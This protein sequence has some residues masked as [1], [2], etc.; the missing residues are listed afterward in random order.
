MLQPVYDNDY[1]VPKMIEDGIQPRW[2]VWAAPGE[3][4]PWTT[5]ADYKS[6]QAENSPQQSAWIRSS[7]KRTAELFDIQSQES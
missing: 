3:A 6:F 1:V 4:T 7:V 5:S 2:Q